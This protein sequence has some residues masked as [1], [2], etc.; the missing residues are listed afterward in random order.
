MVPKK[1][2]FLLD[3][4]LD[5]QL[6]RILATLGLTCFSLKD[7][8]WIGFTNG[9]LSELVRKNDFILITGDKDF[10]Y[11]WEKYLIQV[12]VVSIHPLIL[13]NIEPAIINLF[14]SWTYDLS[15]PFLLILQKDSIRI[16]Q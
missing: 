12:I 4:N 10:I 2:T 6:S 5:V 9:K 13:S 11:L 14:E 16:R 8:E 15:K 7:K 1:A 3:E